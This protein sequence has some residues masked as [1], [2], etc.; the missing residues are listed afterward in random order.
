MYAKIVKL[1]AY[2][3][4]GAGLVFMLFPVELEAGM[5]DLAQLLGLTGTIN[6]VPGTLWHVLSLS[7]MGALV[8]LAFASSRF[9]ENNALYRIIV[10]AKTISV[11]GFIFL[12]LSE[13]SAWIMAAAVDG[14]IAFTLII[15]RTSLKSSAMS[16]GF[17][18]TYSGNKPFYE[19]WY[20]KI[21]I[22]QG[23]A[24]WFRYTLLDGVK[25][26]ASVWA[27]L[28]R[29]KITTGKNTFAL[30][31]L[32]PP[33]CLIIPDHKET[34][35]FETQQQVFHLG[36]NHLDGANAIGQAGTVSWDLQFADN[37]WRFEHVPPLMKALKLAK[38]IY[39]ACFLDLRFSG[40]IN[41][42][43]ETIILK[44]RPGMIGHIYGKKSAHAWAWAHCNNF[45]GERQVIFEGLSAQIK[46]GGNVSPPLTSFV[47]IADNQLY[48]FSSTVQ[49]FK[50]QSEFGN[51]KWTFTAQS[52]EALL[53]GE[54]IAPANIALV[55]YT[56]TDNS[57][58]YC[59][60]SKLADLKLEFTL[61]K[62]G[63]T[64]TFVSQGTCAFELVNRNKPNRAIDL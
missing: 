7:L 60:N 54:A 47:F 29:D 35:R 12:A 37:N 57:N 17:P 43:A 11:A 34:A 38:S 24:F 41:S 49:L 18:R 16:A 9:P 14:F 6:A 23:K 56:D 58:L 61:L 3:F 46:L 40:K 36:G 32:A 50:A 45:V 51:G 31:T 25:H 21:D 30:N 55:E 48:S 52:N 20:G 8:A 26:E 5:N 22:A 4:L 44:D 53:K 39:Y 62:T 19:V 15:S 27:I 59:W 10:L 63:K 42:G 2:L 28:F 33:N 64:E 13:G 1:W